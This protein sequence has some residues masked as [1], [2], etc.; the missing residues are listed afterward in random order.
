MFSRNL[1]VAL[2]EDNIAWADKA[3]NVEQLRR[4]LRNVPE[5]TDLVVLPELFTTG[6]IVG[7]RDTAAHLAERNIDDTIATLHQLA[8]HY[9]LALCGSFLAHTAGQL[10]NRAFFIEANVYKQGYTLAPIVRYRGFNIKLIVC[11]DLR[12]P[13]FCRNVGNAY[14]LL[15]V[16][17]NWPKA[18]ENAWKQLLAA[19]AIENEA[20]VLG[21]NRCGQ[22]PQGIV[23]SEGS[24]Q[25]IDFKGKLI[26]ERATSPIIA[27]DLSLPALA[28]FREK[29]P[30]WHDADSFT[31]NL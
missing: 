12:F 25:I 6:F 4:N 9:N 30:A 22:D 7:D 11:Y 21:V 10:Y 24:S 3:A 17:A 26:T 20:Y 1:R 2:I 29:F 16:V 5:G 8:Q 18:R 28:R 31:I 23:Y 27:A 14:D 19:R 15:V 13:V